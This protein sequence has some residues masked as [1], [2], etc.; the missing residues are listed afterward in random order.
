LGVAGA[1]EEK[2]WEE[3]HAQSAGASVDVSNQEEIPVPAAH[4]TCETTSSVQAPG[5][6]MQRGG[7]LMSLSLGEITILVQEL[8]HALQ[9]AQAALELAE[10]R[11]Q[12]KPT[13]ASECRETP[14]ARI[15]DLQK[16]LHT[17]R[18][19]ALIIQA[20]TVRKPEDPKPVEVK[21]EDD[22]T[23]EVKKVDADADAK[24]AEETKEESTPAADGAAAAATLVTEA[25]AAETTAVELSEVHERVTCD[26]CGLSTIR[27]PRWKCNQCA[28]FDLCDICHGQFRRRG[29]YHIGGHTFRRIGH[30]PLFKAAQHGHAPDVEQ[31]IAA[32]CNVDLANDDG[33]TPL[34]AAAQHGHA[35]IVEQLIA[36]RC[37][38]DLPKT[39]DG[40]TPLYAAA[41]KGHA[42]V[43]EQ[44]IAA[45]CSVDLVSTVKHLN[46]HTHTHT[47]THM[48]IH[49]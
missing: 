6:D 29:Q 40:Q 49:R 33:Q 42:R 12:D 39:D 28:D 20:D 3:Q 13:V 11:S 38:V 23:E 47:H 36:A 44:L 4:I 27:G 19:D 17:A 14:E 35:P 15:L 22:K 34:Y 7:N 16:Q 30:T 25:P 31:L 48:F 9:E 21:K 41:D 26:G 18:A 8:E 32:R 1:G 37:N 43:V 46:T 45:R 5:L 24:P 2:K 10:E